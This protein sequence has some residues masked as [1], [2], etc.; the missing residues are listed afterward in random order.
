MTDCDRTLI[1]ITA[2]QFALISLFAHYLHE[3]PHNHASKCRL[4]EFDFFFSFLF[5]LLFCSSRILCWLIKSTHRNS[6]P[7]HLCLNCL[8]SCIETENCLA[9]HSSRAKILYCIVI[10]FLLTIGKKMVCFF[11]CPFCLYVFNLQSQMNIPHR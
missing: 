2:K 11:L 3:Q 10:Y 1:I 9:N 6:K 7:M 5:F 4:T 8:F